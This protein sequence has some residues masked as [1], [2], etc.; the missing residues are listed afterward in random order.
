MKNATS[1]A[2]ILTLL[3]TGCAAV[4]PNYQT[5][6]ID[7][8]LR[9][10]DGDANSSGQVAADQWWLSFGDDQLNKLVARGMAQ[11]L[12]VRT[13]NERI[14]QAAAA[15]RATGRA[16]QITGDGSLSSTASGSKGSGSSTTNSGD[17]AANYVFDIFGGARRGQEQA[18]A[19]LDGAISDVGT[20]RLA[21]LASL[22]G[23]YVDVRYFQEAMALTRESI[24]TRRETVALTR[25]QRNI[26]VASELDFA[27]AEALLNEVL[28]NL[29]ALET[30][31]YTA[32]YG[33]ATL[34][35]E[36]AGP[37]IKTLERG[38]RQPRPK[39]GAAAGVPADVLRN[40]PDVV[41]A[42][43][44]LAA[45]T[46]AIGVAVADLY[47]SL[48]LDG[49]VT[50]SD[51]SS[52]TFGPTL[53]LP[54]L[55]RTA[56]HAARDQKISVAQQAELTWRG[57]VLAAIE[58]VQTAQTGYLRLQRE[59]KARREALDSYQR[60]LDLSTATYQAGAISLLDLLDAERSR[61]SAQLSLATSVQD[62]A[63]TWITLQIAAG[64]GWKTPTDGN[65]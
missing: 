23:N 64:R 63:M 1:T 43:H 44:D 26:G 39:G 35:G 3:I 25:Q 7:T 17:L 14:K 61:A 21:L 15:L 28:A 60:V 56:L 54:I 55:N 31:F 20:A 40:R 59:A 22:V 9:F 2:L 41:S 4:G 16:S 65:S 33:I 30:G 19:E 51:P 27:N 37:I 36:P 12:D 47:P 5:P 8:P 24:A 46:A 52:W 18:A 49:T 45:A 29:P 50:V 58:E 10:V 53:S 13:A 34:L 11:N 42:E 48:D 57:T 32:A 38:S 6:V 62:L